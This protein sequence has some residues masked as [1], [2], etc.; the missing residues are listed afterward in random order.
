M[1]DPVTAGIGAAGIGMSLLGGITGAAGAAQSGQA[2][3]EQLTYKAGLAKLNA[4]IEHQNANYAMLQGEESAAKYGIRAREQAGAIKAAQ[5]SSN[6]DV[7]TGSAKQVQESQH[8]VSKL[9]MDTIRNNAARTAWNYEAQ[10]KGFEGQ[11]MLDTLAA[12]DVRR[13]TPINVASSLLSAGGSV[14]SK[15]LQGSQQGIFGNSSSQALG[16]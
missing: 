13:A 2:Q 3:A 7:N 8:T 10:A 5:A 9:D 12:K 4:D 11:S 15:W 14:A 16:I 1:A 6:L